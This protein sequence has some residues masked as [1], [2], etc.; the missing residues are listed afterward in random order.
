MSRPTKI[1]VAVSVLAIGAFLASKVMFTT[2]PN[3]DEEAMSRP[4]PPEVHGKGDYSPVSIARD[5]CRKLTNAIRTFHAKRGMR[6]LPE[7]TPA[8]EKRVFVVDAAML[9]A[10]NGSQK[11]LNEAGV[12]YLSGAGL[13]QALSPGKFYVAFDFDGDG[14][15]SDPSAPDKSVSQDILVWNS[16]EDGKPETWADNAYA[17]QKQ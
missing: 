16:G 17:W 8:D 14:S 6:P 2:P 11:S 13:T 12:N 1:L 7:G 5:Q 4:I 10:L 15:I 3:T 9:E